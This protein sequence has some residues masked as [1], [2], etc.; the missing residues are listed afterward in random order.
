MSSLGC[1][2]PLALRPV[3]DGEYE[4]VGQ[5]FVPGIMHGEAILGDLPSNADVVLGL[6][7]H[8]DRRFGFQ[9]TISKHVTFRDKINAFST[10][11]AS[12]EPDSWLRR[13]TSQD[14]KRAAIDIRTFSL[15]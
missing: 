5:C 9:D 13:V 15:V 7:L 11:S 1:P 3:N 14:L 4:V 10:S 12:D 8:G 6:D 2:V